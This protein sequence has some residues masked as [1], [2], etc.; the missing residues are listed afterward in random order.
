[1]NESVSQPSPSASSSSGKVTIKYGVHVREVE[2][3]TTIGDLR[4]KYGQIL[5]IPEDARGYSG[6]NQ[7]SD[8][9]VLTDGTTVEFVRKTGEKG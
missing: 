3:G 7:M 6:T 9:Q 5:R 4:K 2:A 1:M 8:D